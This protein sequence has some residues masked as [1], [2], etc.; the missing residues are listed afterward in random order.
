MK[1]LF[2]ALVILV[3]VVPSSSFAGER[4]TKEIGS[5]NPNYSSLDNELNASASDGKLAGEIDMEAPFIDNDS[6]GLGGEIGATIDAQNELES[7]DFVG[8]DN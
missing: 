3:L 6:G 4:I 7:K 1:S 2:I 8:D 5:D